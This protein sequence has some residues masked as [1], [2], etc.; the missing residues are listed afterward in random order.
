[1]KQDAQWNRTRRVWVLNNPPNH[2]GQY[3]CGIC[4]K[5]VHISDMELDHI[6]PRSGE[7]TSKH[8]STNLQPSH[9]FCNQ[10]KGSKRMKPLISPEEYELRRELD[11]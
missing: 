10:L 9:A 7:P 8:D 11:L 6:I 3:V 4:G 5:T 2:Q 1:M